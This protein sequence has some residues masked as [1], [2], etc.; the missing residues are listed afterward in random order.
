MTQPY[1]RRDSDNLDA[2]KVDPGARLPML[3]R[4]EKL[5]RGD[6]QQD[7]GDKLENFSQIAELWTAT[8]R[9]TLRPGA[10]ITAEEV[11]LCMMQVKIARLSGK[12]DHRDSILDVAGYAGCYDDILDERQR[13]SINPLIGK[14][15]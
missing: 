7:Y 13:I 9:R 5:I 14:E 11:G 3:H 15:K 6:R 1:E 8:L 10:E 2:D 4:A 12:P